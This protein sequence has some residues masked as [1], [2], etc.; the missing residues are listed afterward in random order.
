MKKEVKVREKQSI[1]SRG[2]AQKAECL[3]MI[4][5]PSLGQPEGL[6]KELKPWRVEQKEHVENVQ[7]T[8]MVELSRDTAKAHKDRVLATLCSLL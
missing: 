4:Q 2:L 6:I 5:V 3:T 1:S 8:Q 7:G